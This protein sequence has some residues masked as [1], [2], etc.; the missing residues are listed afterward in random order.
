M[1]LWLRR[2]VFS[3]FLLAG[4][5]AS[6]SWAWDLVPQSST[7]FRVAAVTI[8]VLG[9]VGGVANARRIRQRTH[10]ARRPVRVTAPLAG[11]FGLLLA[12]TIQDASPP[13]RMLANAAVCGVL[14]FFLIALV[15]IW[16][17][18]LP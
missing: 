13:W 9:V 1:P 5:I 15:P 10:P 14:L 16:R 4:L 6:A 12:V 7:P 3:A 2:T 8:L 11:G 18:G 17:Y